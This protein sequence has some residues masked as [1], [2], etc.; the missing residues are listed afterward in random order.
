MACGNVQGAEEHVTT[1]MYDYSKI[2]PVQ[3]KVTFPFN[4][5]LQRAMIEHRTS[6][7]PS[8]CSIRGDGGLIQPQYGKV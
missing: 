5:Y 6:L 2:M 4:V 1:T 7:G 8:Y 3:S